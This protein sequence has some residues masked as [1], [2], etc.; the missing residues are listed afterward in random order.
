MRPGTEALAG[1][2]TLRRPAPELLTGDPDPG[3]IFPLQD[4]QLDRIEP[5]PGWLKEP[6][7]RRSV[8]QRV[9]L[10]SGWLRLC[11]ETTDPLGEGP[12]GLRG[13]RRQGACP[14]KILNGMVILRQA[15]SGLSGRVA[16]VERLEEDR[17]QDRRRYG[18]PGGSIECVQA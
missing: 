9:C 16:L 10:G 14:T 17:R 18:I 7:S 2:H 13:R 3:R 4:R 8:G 12:D 5:G 15:L 11:H 1:T 6:R